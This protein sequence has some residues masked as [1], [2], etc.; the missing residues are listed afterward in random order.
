MRKQKIVPPLRQAPRSLRK[1]IGP[2]RDTRQDRGH[3]PPILS[4]IA[5]HTKPVLRGSPSS[6]RR[7]AYLKNNPLH[8]LQI[9]KYL[10]EIARLRIP[11]GPKHPHQALGRTLKRRTK[12]RETDRSMDIFAKH[13]LATSELSRHHLRESFR[14]KSP[15]KLRIRLQIVS[16]GI[17]EWT[18]SRFHR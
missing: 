1:R 10:E 8:L 13:D 9:N 7:R 5:R 15:P 3:H 2:M 11:L 14:K 4:L 6:I 16:N 17:A 12:C 18:S